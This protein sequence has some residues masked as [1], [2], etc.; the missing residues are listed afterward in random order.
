MSFSCVS[1]YF[2]NDVGGGLVLNINK[3]N[4]YAPKK[5]GREGITVF[6]QNRGRIKGYS[7][8]LYLYIRLRR[9]LTGPNFF[10]LGKLKV[11]NFRKLKFFYGD[12]CTSLAPLLYYFLV[13]K[14]RG[15]R[16]HD[17]SRFSLW[18][19]ILAC[20]MIWLDSLTYFH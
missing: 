13:K 20:G 18:S 19:M 2:S 1:S 9:R 17:D 3:D 12:I 10:F 15:G 16:G 8:I 14:V 5:C 7:N 4:I 11:R 6:P